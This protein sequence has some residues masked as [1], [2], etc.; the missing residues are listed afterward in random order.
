MLLVCP[1]NRCNFY[2]YSEFISKI[3]LYNL[4][5]IDLNLNRNKRMM[6]MELTYSKCASQGKEEDL[7]CLDTECDQD[8]V[9][10]C[11]WCHLKKHS[12]HSHNIHII[13]EL[14]TSS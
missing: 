9:V 1:N 4:F 11:S 3:Q 14:V 10:I 13:K 12:K 5:I 8:Q 6:Q 7:V 2:C